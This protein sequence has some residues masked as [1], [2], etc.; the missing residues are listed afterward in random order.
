MLASPGVDLRREDDDSSVARVS[1]LEFFNA[2][3]VPVFHFIFQKSKR[4]TTCSQ[5]T[6]IVSASGP[7][8]LAGWRISDVPAIRSVDIPP[9]SVGRPVSEDGDGH[10]TG[11]V[12]VGVNVALMGCVSFHI[13]FSL[14]I[15]VELPVAVFSTE[16]ADGGKGV[17]AVYK[18]TQRNRD[19]G[20]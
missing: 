11:A 20:G 18:K 5:P 16:R 3:G 13:A 14:N 4:N 10:A 17:G 19:R 7:G 2:D 15:A 9:M 6:R 1:S 12:F 8:W